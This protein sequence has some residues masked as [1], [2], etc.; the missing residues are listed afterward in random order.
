MKITQIMW[1]N[2]EKKM[3]ITSIGLANS[4]TKSTLHNYVCRL[5]FRETMLPTD[6]E[7]RFTESSQLIFPKE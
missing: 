4:I 3:E 2:K 7:A 1:R 6:I 5:A